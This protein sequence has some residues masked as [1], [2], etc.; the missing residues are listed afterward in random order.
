MIAEIISIIKNEKSSK[1][2]NSSTF[3]DM[4]IKV[5]IEELTQIFLVDK[6]VR[7]PGEDNPEKNTISFLKDRNVFP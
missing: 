3:W 5:L 7:K 4:F 6:Y 2:Y 1:N